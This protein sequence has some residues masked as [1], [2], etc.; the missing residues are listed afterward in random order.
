MA[1]PLHPSRP[2]PADSA[3]RVGIKLDEVTAAEWLFPGAAHVGKPAVAH[4]RIVFDHFLQ[5]L[6]TRFVELAAHEADPE[7]YLDKRANSTRNKLF[8]AVSVADVCAHLI[9]E[10]QFGTVEDATERMAIAWP[11]GGCWLSP[12]MP[13]ATYSSSATWLSRVAP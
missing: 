7:R 13:R 10:V 4:N 8:E 6:R 5:Y 1:A 3:Q 9:D 12:R 11:L 2:A